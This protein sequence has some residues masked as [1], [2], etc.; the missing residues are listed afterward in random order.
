MLTKDPAQRIGAIADAK[1]IKKHAF[2]NEVD[3]DAV[4][5]KEHDMP[6]KPKVRGPEDTS[7]IDKLF[8]K[9][10]L[11]ETQVDPNA[12]TAHQ[13]KQAHF[14]GFTYAGAGGA[15]GNH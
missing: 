1:D 5:R 3:W 9:E 12:L 8:T 11:E 13:K 7:C 14:D 10:R 6:F 15:L 4:Q 2:F